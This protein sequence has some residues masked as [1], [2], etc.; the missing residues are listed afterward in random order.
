MMRG[1]T[2]IPNEFSLT[3]I[4]TYKHSN[5]QALKY[6]DLSAN[7]GHVPSMVQRGLLYMCPK[8]Q[9]KHTINR[10]YDPSLNKNNILSKIEVKF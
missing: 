5:N 10:L 6:L 4:N 9:G 3:S 1:M 2:A 8:A 7:L